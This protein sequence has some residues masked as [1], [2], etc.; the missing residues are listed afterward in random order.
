MPI[1]RY[2]DKLRREDHDMA[3]YRVGIVGVF[4]KLDEGDLRLLH[5]SLAQLSE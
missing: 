3:R 4:D 2:G 5:E 1:I